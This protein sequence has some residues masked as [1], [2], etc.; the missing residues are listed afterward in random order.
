MSDQF[1][2]IF[3]KL[4]DAMVARLT[5]DLIEEVSDAT[6]AGLIR[7]GRLQADP[8]DA[9]RGLNILIHLGGDDWPDQLNIGFAGVEAPTYEIGGT[10]YWR[11][12]FIVELTLFFDNEED[13]QLARR[14]ATIIMAHAHKSLYTIPIPQGHDSFGEA[15]LGIQISQSVQN[16]AGGD[17]TF[18]WRSK[19]YVE[20]YTVIQD[21]FE[22]I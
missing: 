12:H 20:W 17:G 11:R 6:K 9:D 15:A 22:D 2:S 13:R 8:T 18:I 7:F 4:T 16:E 5:S 14:K 3:N 1:T 19:L 21:G 10:Q